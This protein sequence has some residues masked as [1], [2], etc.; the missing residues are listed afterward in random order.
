MFFA[1]FI[2]FLMAITNNFE[3]IRGIVFSYN[4][5]ESFAIITRIRNININDN[6]VLSFKA[7]KFDNI[8]MY[9]LH[10]FLLTDYNP[11]IRPVYNE[12]TTSTIGID[13]TLMQILEIVSNKYKLYFVK[14]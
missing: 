11:A 10:K 12:N 5:L 7:Q 1:K 6:I 2:G 8:S 9:K 14:I 3:Q 13:L 4:V